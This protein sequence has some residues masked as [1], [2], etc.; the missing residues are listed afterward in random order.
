M[1][2]SGGDGALYTMVEA[3]R[4]KGV[5]YQTVSRAVIA[6]RL[7]ARRLGRQ[8]LIA[9]A[10]LAA[11]APERHKAPRKYRRGADAEA[12]AAPIDAVTLDRAAL[13]RRIA[14]LAMALT[15]AAPGLPVAD[16]RGIA[17]GLAALVARAR[18]DDW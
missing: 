8:A 4:H 14:M 16:L 6:G 7:P 18:R 15:A 13:E 1:G 11:W 9:A 17:D 5:S 3:A 2:D 12:S 10:D